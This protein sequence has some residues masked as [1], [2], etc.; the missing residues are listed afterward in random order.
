MNKTTI[1]AIAGGTAC[2]KTTLAKQ[3]INILKDKSVVL[4]STDNY[5]KDYSYLTSED[6]KKINYDHPDALDIELLK[7]HLFQLT[8]GQSVEQQIYDFKNNIR[9]NK[10]RFIKPSKV[11]ILEG[12]LLLHIKTIRDLCNIKLFV[13]TD[14]DIRFIRRLTRDID[15][16]K[17]TLNSVINQYLKTVKPMHDILVE[18]SIKYAD[19][20]IPYYEGNNVALNILLSRIESLIQSEVAIVL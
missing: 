19:L 7:K 20:I 12:I 11:I 3:I 1:I 17:R 10:T 8:N 18:P 2:G 16:R 9:T 14:D 13:K 15:N 6:R 5:Y 4:L